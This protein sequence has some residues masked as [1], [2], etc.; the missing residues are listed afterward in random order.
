MHILIL[1]QV[2]N[3]LFHFGLILLMLC[4]DFHS[5]RCELLAEGCPKLFQLVEELLTLPGYQA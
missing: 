1:E 5:N 2:Y 4:F 3:L